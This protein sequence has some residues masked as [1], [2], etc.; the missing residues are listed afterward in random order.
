MTILQAQQQTDKWIQTVGGGY[1]SPLTNMILLQEE[2][3]ELAR[4]I[5]RTYG[6]QKPKPGD[7]DHTIAEELAD[8]LWVTLCLANQTG[9]DLTEAFRQGLRKRYTRDRNRFR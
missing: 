8:I 2:I 5:A 7:L 1:F 6:E 3:G 4:I 9:T